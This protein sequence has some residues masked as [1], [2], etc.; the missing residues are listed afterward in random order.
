MAG[1]QVMRVAHRDHGVI[2]EGKHAGSIDLE[3]RSKDIQKR[4]GGVERRNSL[5]EP[6]ETSRLALGRSLRGPPGAS[7]RLARR[8]APFGPGP[9]SALGLAT[10][11]PALRV[12]RVF[13][14]Q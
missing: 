8:T 5:H 7:Q 12:L 1:R 13:A 11:L 3:A 9:G 4:P 2:P 14:V 6:P 10:P